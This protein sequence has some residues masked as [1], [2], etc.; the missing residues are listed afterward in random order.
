MDAPKTLLA[1]AGADPTPNALSESALVLIDCQLE[2]VDGRLALPQ[3]G[4]AL[5]EAARVLERART[6][7][8]PVIHIAHR[9]A[10]GGPFDPDG[11]SGR[12]APEVAPREGEPVIAKRLP[13]AFAGTELDATLRALDR[14]RLIVVGFMTH[15]CVSSTVRAALDLGYRS[16]VVASAAATRDLPACGGGV[17]DARALHEASLVALADRF[18]V[19]VPT[20]GDLPD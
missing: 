17:L 7:G 8:A 19:I 3:I 20:A 1:L 15:M 5:A 9:G 16:T 18:A 14:K 12:I 4:P 10:P 13:N 2:Y 6:A 11:R